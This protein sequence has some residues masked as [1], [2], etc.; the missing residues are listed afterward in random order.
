MAEKIPFNVCCLLISAGEF[1]KINKQLFNHFEYTKRHSKNDHQQLHIPLI[2]TTRVVLLYE[3]NKHN[4]TTEWLNS[5]L[6]PESQWPLLLKNLLSVAFCSDE[7]VCIVW[8]ENQLAIYN[9]AFSE[10]IDRRHARPGQTFGELLSPVWPDIS[11]V[12]E[13]AIRDKES[14]TR[15][16]SLSVLRRD[17]KKDRKTV[18]KCVP[19]YEENGQTPLLYCT[20]L[21]H[22][23][24]SSI[25]DTYPVTSFPDV[26]SSYQNILDNIQ[27]GVMQVAP[28]TAILY[29]NKTI[30][31]MLG[32]TDDSFPDS[33]HELLHPQNRRNAEKMQS[34]EK[35]WYTTSHFHIELPLR[36]QDGTY[37]LTDNEISLKLN[38]KNQPAYSLIASIRNGKDFS[39]ERRNLLLYDPLT[40][41]PGR[42]YSDLLISDAIEQAAT[43]G[44]TFAI[45]LLNINRFKLVNES[46]GHD[47]GDE[48]LKSVA[49][50]LTTSLRKED[51]V[52]RMGNDEFIVILPNVKSDESIDVVAHNLLYAIS[53][54]LH[55]AGHEI[56]ISASIG[57]SAFPRD[58]KDIDSLLKYADIA[59]I[60]AKRS[61]TNAFRFFNRSMSVSVLDQLLSETNLMKAL[62]NREFLAYYQ[63][64]LSL[65]TGN[66]VGLEALIRW[67]HPKKG[68]ISAADFILQAEKI[69]LI[70]RIGEFVL[71]EVTE[72]L[73]KWRDMHKPPIPVAINVS[74]TDLYDSHL[75]NTLRDILDKTGLSPNLFELE[76]TETGLIEDLHKVR[77]TLTAIRQM[78]VA[79]S[80]DDFGT[81]YSSL[82]YLST[83]PVDFLKIDSSF[84]ANVIVNP[85]TASIV[86]STISLAHSLNM[87]VIAEGVSTQEQLEFLIHRGCDQIQGYLCSRALSPAELETFLQ[88][89]QP[90]RLG[91]PF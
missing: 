21:P 32:Y 11:P 4:E 69:G 77:T 51:L 55:L 73:V 38:D 9:E 85:N 44:Q 70:R 67:R 22:P 37:C 54:P 59:M 36:C 19:V 34:W 30:R 58:S 78:G 33:F 42:N 53:R 14:K 56:T 64:R 13:S 15:E 87:K 49:I 79:V 17:K 10:L 86:E 39:N 16:L 60:E 25:P 18:F 57:C 2:N 66:I 62:E 28:D 84:I 89:F 71:N 74:S 91:L 7:P 20:F 5:N 72:Q 52:I 31:K 90:S 65:S 81:G 24:D 63:P 26:I 43:T 8:G 61:G 45:L 35:I 47:V 50:R 83:L 1:T 3:M 46:L 48:L 40:S 41:L 27:V 6:G 29:S 80:I 75:E 68:L 82:S 76:I 88:Q 12:V 23:D